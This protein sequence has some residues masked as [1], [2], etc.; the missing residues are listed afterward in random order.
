MYRSLYER[1]TVYF[2]F[3][4]LLSFFG[5]HVLDVSLSV[6]YKA[7]GGILTDIKYKKEYCEDISRSSEFMSVLLV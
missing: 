5:V 4:M 6:S 2:F 1:V 3:H 7:A